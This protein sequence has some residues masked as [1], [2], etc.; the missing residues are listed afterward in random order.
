MKTIKTASGKIVN[1]DNVDKEIWEAIGLEYGWLRTAEGANEMQEISDAIEVPDADEV[2]FGDA[3]EISNAEPPIGNT[4]QDGAQELANKDNPDAN[5]AEWQI[6]R[7]MP[8]DNSTIEEV[9][10]NDNEQRS[11]TQQQNLVE[12]ERRQ[13]LMQDKQDQAGQQSEQIEDQIEEMDALQQEEKI[14]EMNQQMVENVNQTVQNTVN[15]TMSFSGNL[16]T[17]PLKNK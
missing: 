11:Q 5:I 2:M 9:N 7:Q 15:K 4:V 3:P 16:I 13:Q 17:L 8:P 10:Q 6:E 12:E 1:I 14:Q